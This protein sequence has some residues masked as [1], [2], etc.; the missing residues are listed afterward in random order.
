MQVDNADNRE[1]DFSD[2]CSHCE[3]GWS[4]CLGT[5]PPISDSRKSIIE[6]FLKQH[7]IIVEGAFVEEEYRFPKEHS[8]GYCVF[9]DAKT[10]LCVIH[11]VKPETCVAGPVTFDINVDDG[12]IEWFLKFETLCQ[13]AGVL[14]RNKP[15]LK[16]HFESAK[17]EILRLVDELDA[18]ALRAV[19][20]KDEPETFKFAEDEIDK[21]ILDKLC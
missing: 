8:D 18:G 10:G 7:G 15:A 5:R 14:S 21:R 2:T 1:D 9:R 6:T 20:A 3:T 13:L 12:K 11:S 17:K 4:C 16:R 19:L